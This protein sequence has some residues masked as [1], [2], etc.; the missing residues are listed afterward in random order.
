MCYGTGLK[1]NGPS[2]VTKHTTLGDNVNFKGLVI[3]GGG[4][5]DWEQLPFWTRVFD[6]NTES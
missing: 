3:N 2:A 5:A 6:N 1:V 4:S